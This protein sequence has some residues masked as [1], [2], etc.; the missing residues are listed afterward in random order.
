MRIIG[1]TGGIGS[2]KS[3][4]AEI[5]ESIG[6]YIINADEIAKELLGN[7]KKAYEEV[8]DF[9]GSEILDEN[10]EIDRKKLASIVFN[11]KSKLAVLNEITHKQ[12]YRKMEDI[13]NQLKHKGF[14]GIVILDVPI[15]N[16]EFKKMSGEIWVVDCDDETR[17]SR[18]VKR[19]GITREEA[20]KRM[21]AQLKRE[22]YLRLADRVI[23]N[24]GTKEELKNSVINLLEE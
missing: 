12:V 5:L 18:V 7:G 20:I 9:F 6:A 21:N 14:N 24:K 17:I 8:L 22:D 10:K 16:E 11:D 19:M 13:I 3:T 2:G 4:T 23:R 1:L 15:P